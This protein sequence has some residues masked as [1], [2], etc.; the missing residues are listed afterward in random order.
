[1][2]DQIRFLCSII[3]KVT[4]ADLESRLKSHDSGISAIEHGVLRHLYNGITSM[5]E[6]SRL[7]GVVPS[8]LVYVVDG[9]VKKK[10]VR[11]GKDPKDRR[12][13][14]LQIEK[15]GAELFARIPRMEA[16][17]VLVQRLESMKE[18]RRCE[19][20]LLLK[21]FVEGLVGAERLY[22]SA[23]SEEAAASSPAARDG[24]AAS[25]VKVRKPGS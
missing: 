18:T 10:L 4:R 24:Q 22:R 6:I 12:R 19:L 1:M 14:P 5:A 7:M 15:R 9:L 20:V 23:K 8:T 25:A 11:R 21:E 3:T 16:S 13:E 17:S 2:A